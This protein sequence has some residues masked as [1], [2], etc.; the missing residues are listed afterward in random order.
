MNLER[1][2]KLVLIAFWCLL[3]ITEVRNLQKV[4][5]CEILYTNKQNCQHKTKLC[6]T[7]F[8]TKFGQ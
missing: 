4:L 2:N 3:L 6:K 1:Q 7:S 5:T 8:I